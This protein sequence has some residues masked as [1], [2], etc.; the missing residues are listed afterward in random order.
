MQLSGWYLYSHS[1]ILE[2]GSII[3][4]THPYNKEAD[5]SPYKSH[6]HHDID[7][8]YSHSLHILALLFTT[9]YLIFQFAKTLEEYTEPYN[10][11][12]QCIPNR[13]GR[14]PPTF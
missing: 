10:V 8:V 3:T 7:Q 12:V 5:S 9:L 4:H 6:V 11:L 2:D 13:N 14:S 1:H